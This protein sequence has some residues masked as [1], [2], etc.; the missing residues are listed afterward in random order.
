MTGPPF[1]D[2]PPVPPAP[3]DPPTAAPTATDPGTPTER[4]P[5]QAVGRA[6][7]GALLL[8]AGVLWLLDVTGAIDLRWRTALPI[9]LVVVGL[10]CIVVSLRHR[11][12]G[13]V[14]AGVLLSV[15]VVIT[16]LLPGQ[17]GFSIGEQDHRAEAP[18]DLR[19]EYSHGI[20]ELRIDLR[21]LVIESDTTVTAG[22][23]LGELVVQ[24]PD[25]V[26]IEVDATAGVGE[27]SALGRSSSGFGVRFER[28]FPEPEAP[29]LRLE[30]SV[31]MGKVEVRR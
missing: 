17:I 13:L 18:A 26:T 11:S 24:V 3:A 22:V 19:D 15:V 29:T 16:S 14:T 2:P 10:A 23:G 30:L 27:V 6:V 1:P 5:G 9:A 20:G 7:W 31:G 21:D 8:A 25:G 28:R 12:S 4:R